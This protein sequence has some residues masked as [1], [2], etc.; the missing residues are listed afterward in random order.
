LRTPLCQRLGIEVPVIQAP[1]GA[2]ATPELAAAVAGAGGLGMLAGS[3]SSAGTMRTMLRRTR[4]LTDRPVGINLAVAFPVA[5]QLHAALDEG[6]R[7][8][9]TFW[10]DPTPLRAD[11]RAAGGVT[12]LHTV[13]TAAEA[14]HA[15]DAGVD[16][17]VAQGWEAG[18]HVW[19]QVATLALV[20]QVVDAVAPV[21]VVA[22]GGVADGRGLA[23]VLALGAQAAWVGTRLLAAAEADVHDHYRRRILD[24][25][26][27]DALHTLCFCDG[28]PDAPHRALRN[29]T[30]DRWEQAGRPAAPHR[31]GEG[32]VVASDEL[33]GDLPRYLA[34]MPLRSTHGD[35]DDMV[36][37]AGQCAG[38]VH[39]I[40]PAADIVGDMVADASAVLARLAAG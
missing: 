7:V 2:A 3:W 13:G 6:V 12:H 36:L 30:I 23:A 33:L 22:A 14:R 27:E 40:R 21:P 34:M 20:P 35:V 29:A 39:E 32:E 17:V 10:G 19:G 1:M 28:W 38:L 25:R 16:V 26:G 4:E 5:D 9:S 8:V 31:P 15:V 24:A 37:Y 18:G 11:I